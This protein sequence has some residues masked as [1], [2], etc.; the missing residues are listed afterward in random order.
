MSKTRILSMLLALIMVLG[1]LP[2]GVFAAEEA[3]PAVTAENLS[4]AQPQKSAEQASA[5]NVIDGWQSYSGSTWLNYGDSCLNVSS[6]TNPGTVFFADRKFENYEMEV[7]MQL[8]SGSWF[9][10]MYRA[11]GDEKG[12]FR[13][14]TGSG[15]HNL[16][17]HITKDGDGWQ[18]DS[19]NV[20]TDYSKYTAGTIMDIKVRVENNQ[21][22]VWTKMSTDSD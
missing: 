2:V 10:I 8:N 3:Q 4:T 7:Q 1:M 6:Q 19:V 5:G 22:S 13:V 12:F 21:V 20:T 17:H 16:H 18:S 9:G 11:I 15:A 14:G